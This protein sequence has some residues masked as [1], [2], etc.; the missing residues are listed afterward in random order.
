[1]TPGH[2]LTVADKLLIAAASLDEPGNRPFSAEELVVAA[3]EHFPDA[4]GLRGITD[5]S[6][7]S[8]HPD[9]NRV[10]A[11]IMGSKPLRRYGLLT[12]VGNKRYEIT[13]AGRRKSRVL[14][15]VDAAQAPGASRSLERGLQDDLRRLARSRAHD[16][17]LAGRSSDLTFHDACGFFGISPR[18]S[19]MDLEARLAHVAAVLDGAG[20]LTSESPIYL[21]RTGGQ[22]LDAAG[23][24][25]LR[26]LQAVLESSFDAE[27]AVI[28][29][30]TDERAT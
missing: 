22:E 7:R 25:R 2:R 26:D 23:V 28:R 30:R 15:G 6:G 11:E 10:F 3:W 18:S 20:E 5:E 14:R 29:K 12:K 21:D 4:F 1:M 8:L 13:E 24:E 27:L 17:L 9:S 19:A 16:K